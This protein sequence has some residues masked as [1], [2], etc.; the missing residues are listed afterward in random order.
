MRPSVVLIPITLLSLCADIA[1]AEEGACRKVKPRGVGV[2]LRFIC[3]EN[4]EL[5]GGLC[6]PKCEEGYEPVGCCFCRK[7]GCEE[8]STD[9]GAACTKPEDYRRGVGYV[10]W[11][12]GKCVRESG[13][14]CE[15]Y[16]LLWYPKCKPGYHAS[17]CCSC[18]PDCPEGYV[19]G[20]NVCKKVSYG[21]GVGK[22]RPGCTDEKELDGGLCYPKCPNGYNGRGPVCW[23]KCSGNMSHDCNSQVC[24]TNSTTCVSLLDSAS[25]SLCEY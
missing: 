25:L 6:Y 8:L 18:S 17:G 10:L 19:D 5:Y 1:I 14:E 3:N 20:G 7:K 16:G 11:D 24:A 21:R 9:I 23:A 12:Y 4:E 15:R 13:G 2:V 22:S